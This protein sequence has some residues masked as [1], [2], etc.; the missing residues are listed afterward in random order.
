VAAVAFAA[1]VLVRR[2]AT[3]SALAAPAFLVVFLLASPASG[4]IR[5]GEMQPAG[6]RLG[7]RRTPPIVVL[8]FD[9]LPLPSLIRPD[10]TLDESRYANFESLRRVSTWYRN[11]TTPSDGTRYAVPAMLTGVAPPLWKDRVA[12]HHPRSIFTALGGVYAF[13][14]STEGICPRTICGGDR[15]EARESWPVVV[16]RLATSG[17]L[18]YGH[19]VTPASLDG[20]LG[21]A[22]SLGLD[23]GEGVGELPRS[24]VGRTSIPDA[25]WREA[26]EQISRIAPADPPTVDL[27]SVFMPHRP[28]TLLPSGQTHSAYD[29]TVPGLRQRAPWTRAKQPVLSAYQAH[30]A[31]VGAADTLLG[32]LMDRLREAQMYDEA[33][34]VVVAD[35]GQGFVPGHPHRGDLTARTLP[36]IAA[37]PFFIKYPGQKRGRVSDRPVEVTDLFPTI[38]DVLGAHP[39]WEMQGESLTRGSSRSTR[40][41]V[42]YGGKQMTIPTDFSRRVRR[43]AA[44]KYAFTGLPLVPDRPVETFYA[45]GEDP[46]I[47]G[48]P[49]EEF[50]RGRPSAARFRIEDAGAYRDVDVDGIVVPSAVTAFAEGP[51]PSGYVVAAVNGVVAAVADPVGWEGRMRIDALFWPGFL[52]D[53]ANDIRLFEWDG[54][55]LR[56]IRSTN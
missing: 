22:E 42:S 45:V 4:V 37:V 1:F 26:V 11:T 5:T 48:I 46:E 16:R 56:P 14:G 20:R 54:R 7:F 44:R 21:A 18:V 24:P 31:Q 32:E 3:W 25:R 13:R 30:L 40:S 35:H 9:E 19:I 27:V 17:S 36:E 49:V 52:T 23:V 15:A 8:R 28:W 6:P 53:G 34:I 38:L 47:V 43:A 12:A 10:G 2:L 50:A 51:A 33:M 41:I 29:W 39:G 55:S